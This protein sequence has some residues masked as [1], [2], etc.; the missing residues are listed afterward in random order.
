[1][2]YR[3]ANS[4][5]IQYLVHYR[6]LQLIDEGLPPNANMSIDEELA[7]YFVSSISDGSLISW[8]AVDDNEIVATSGICFYQLP[9]TF[10]NPTGRVAYVTN[11]FTLPKYRKQGIA[12][13]KEIKEEAGL[14]II[15]IRLVAVQDRNKH[16][17]PQYAYG[18]CKVFVICNAISG[19]FQK[20]PE[21]S[22]SRYFSIEELPELAN[23]KNTIEQIHMCFDAYRD[24]NWIVQFD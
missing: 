11:M 1:M 24:E 22:E 4:N 20:N 2:D 21:T 13:Q 9:P 18:V 23:E 12:S 19:E 16:N 14:D 17:V 8:L 15:P 3:K 5:D 10:S 7:N 6:K